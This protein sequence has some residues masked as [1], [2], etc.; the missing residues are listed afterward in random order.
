MQ[1]RDVGQ[2]VLPEVFFDLGGQLRLTAAVMGQCEQRDHGAARLPVAGLLQ[3]H[4]EH[5]AEGLTREELVAVDQ[6]HQ[7]HGLFAQRMDD[8]AVMD[9]VAMRAVAGCAGAWQ[10]QQE[11]RPQKQIEPV[12]I[13]PHPKPMTDQPGRHGVKNLA[14]QKAAG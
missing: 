10:L 6:S 3:Q 12:I 8:V 2:P 11:G 9:H 4:R 5:V 13:E 14:Q 7:G 1:G